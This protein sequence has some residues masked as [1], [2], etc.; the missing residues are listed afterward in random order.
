MRFELKN[1]RDKEGKSIVRLVLNSGKEKKRIHT[2]LKI[3]PKYF[4]NKKD[5]WIKPNHPNAIYLNNYLSSVYLKYARVDLFAEILTFEKALDLYLKAKS[6]DGIQV[7][8]LM[9][10]R[11]SLHEWRDFLTYRNKLKMSI[12]SYDRNLVTEYFNSLI[13]SGNKRS[14]ANHKVKDLVAMMNF[15]MSNMQLI[16]NNPLNGIKFKNVGNAVKRVLNVTQIREIK[17]FKPRTSLEE[18]GQ[19]MWLF[20]F[21]SKGLRISDIILLKKKDRQSEEGGEYLTIVSQKTRV[22]LRIKVTPETKEILEKYNDRNTLYLLSLGQK[23]DS[24]SD[25][26]RINAKIRKGIKLMASRLDISELTGVHSAR[27]AFAQLANVSKAPI[28]EIQNA[29]GHT[30]VTTTETYLD[31]LTPSSHEDLVQQVSSLIDG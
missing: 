2:E 30:K 20:S 13:T 14:T 1:Y 12:L 23:S 19:D 8:T 25:V 18:L 11:T 4:Q 6:F 9:K 26:D 17:S 27:S 15:L 10:I 24:I 7:R 16:P 31:R 3:E 22:P 28:Q 5:A 29:L 21:Y